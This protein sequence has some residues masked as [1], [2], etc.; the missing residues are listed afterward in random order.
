[1]D[2][3][4]SLET[5]FL[6]QLYSRELLTRRQTST[7]SDEVQNRLLD[8]ARKK[9]VMDLDSAHLGDQLVGLELEYDLVRVDDSAR[10][11]DEQGR[12]GIGLDGDSHDM[13]VPG[14][15]KRVDPASAKGI[16]P[17]TFDYLEQLEARL[18]EAARDLLP[19]DAL[20]GRD[21]ALYVRGRVLIQQEQ[22]YAMF[23]SFCGKCNDGDISCRMIYFIDGE[24]HC[25]KGCRRC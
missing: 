11:A 8:V 1:M 14:D 20:R 21:L 10:Y 23:N 19:R 4:I 7:L 22:R 13:P 2:E 17:I 24:K 15:V 18:E 25:G 12:W 3:K 9:I 6:E 16:G 5:P